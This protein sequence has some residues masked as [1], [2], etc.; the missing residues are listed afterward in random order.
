LSIGLPRLFSTPSAAS[1]LAS[2]VAEP[3]ATNLSKI[4]RTVAASAS[5][6][7]SL[8]SRTS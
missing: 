8:R 3:M 6:T 7:T 5:L 4:I 1:A 2:V